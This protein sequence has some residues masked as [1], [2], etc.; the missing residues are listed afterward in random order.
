MSIN[1]ELLRR[2]Y[3]E[4]FPQNTIHPLLLIFLAIVILLLIPYL[5]SKLLE[6]RL[7]TFWKKIRPPRPHLNQLFSV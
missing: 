2:L 7:A 5:Y 4:W 1:Y 6:D 3:P